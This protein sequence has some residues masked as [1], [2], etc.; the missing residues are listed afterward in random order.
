MLN[1]RG[2]KA[3]IDNE[4][5]IDIVIPW[6]DSNDPEWRKEKNKYMGNTSGDIDARD[7]RYREWNNLQYVFRSIEKFAPWVNRVHFITCG[8]LPEWINKDCPKLHI[9]NHKDY[10]P[11]EYLPT[12][13]SHVIE[14]N[15]HRIEGLSDK[16]VYFN[17]DIFLLR[18]VKPTDFF[19]N[20]LPCDCNIQNLLVPS[21]VTFTP[22]VFKTVGYIN[23]HFSKRE[24]ILK[25]PGKWLNP[26][27]GAVGITRNLL[28]APWKEYT[29]FYNHHLAVSYLKSTF[30]E[31]WNEEPELL[32]ETCR[33][34]FRDNNDVNQYI[35]RFWQ[36]A[37]GRFT[38]N[39]LH[40]KY[41]K[42]TG[43]NTGKIIKYI[44]GR[45]GRMIC[46]NDDVFEGDFETIKGEINGALDKLLPD[47]SSF[48]K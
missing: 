4:A 18:S 10:I 15:M 21:T 9:V 36:I 43:N 45:K 16:F 2:N 14:L 37:S 6:V 12:F 47:K 35:C 42:I 34:R 19:R 20:G 7:C 26:K 3:G 38:P 23:K 41:F 13:S 27:Y 8:H 33:H 46:I 24:S 29:G 44:K 48:E 40:G 28:F 25:H 30:K 39:D 32:D 5:K 31:V 17:D 1:L 11:E 22:I